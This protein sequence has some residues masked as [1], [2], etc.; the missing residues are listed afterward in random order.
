MTIDID[1]RAAL[2]V[3]LAAGAMLATVGAEAQ[4]P[5]AAKGYSHV[6][7]TR[8]GNEHHDLAGGHRSGSECGEE[9]ALGGRQ[10]GERLEIELSCLVAATVVELPQAT[11][12]RRKGKRVSESGGGVDEREE[13]RIVLNDGEP[14]AHPREP[15][16][17][18]NILG[19]VLRG[20]GT[21]RIPHGASPNDPRRER[22]VLHGLHST[23]RIVGPAHG[24]P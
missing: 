24:L 4:T 15:R 13:A 16:G 3:A 18:P 11:H 8:E 19:A 23:R 12:S 14:L 9:D 22:R 6:S 21:G 7:T 10:D 5:G 20:I 17:G 1:R 2:G